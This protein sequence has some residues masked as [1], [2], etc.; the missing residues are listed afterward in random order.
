MVYLYLLIFKKANNIVF[1]Q[2]VIIK[3]YYEWLYIVF[4]LILRVL[5]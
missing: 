2:N 4:L 1:L 5:S 3:Q